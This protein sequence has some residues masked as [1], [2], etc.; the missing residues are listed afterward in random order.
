MYCIDFCG[1]HIQAQALS[2]S[3]RPM[4]IRLWP[5]SFSSSASD[6]SGKQCDRLIRTISRDRLGSF[7]ISQPMPAPN[8]PTAR[9]GSI[10]NKRRKP[11]TS[12]PLNFSTDNSFLQ[13]RTF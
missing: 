9:H 4:S 10:A 1:D 7:H 11:T 13:E 2:V 5:T 8:A 3:V 12:A 6:S